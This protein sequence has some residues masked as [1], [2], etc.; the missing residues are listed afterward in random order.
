MSENAFSNEIILV[1]PRE[2]VRRVLA[3]AAAVTPLSLSLLMASTSPNTLMVACGAAFSMAAIILGREK[4]T[5]SDFLKKADPL[6][7]PQHQRYA[8]YLKHLS[9]ASGLKSPP[10]LISPRLS[11]NNKGGLAFASSGHSF[12]WTAL[13]GYK[14]KYI[15]A[16]EMAHIARRDSENAL[17]YVLPLLMGLGSSLALTFSSLSATGISLLSLSP[18]IL[19][20]LL[21]P[22]MPGK[23][24]T[25]LI[26]LEAER[27]AVEIT[28]Q[29]PFSSYSD[30]DD[31]AR[32]CARIGAPHPVQL[33]A[34]IGQ[35]SPLNARFNNLCAKICKPLTM[36][37]PSPVSFH[38]LGK[39]TP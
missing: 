14:T 16:H 4:H 5:V 13:A 22:N 36:K 17:N 26:E 8:L 11:F 10:T 34:A 21:L 39:T 12:V 28:G 38:E 18:V 32:H 23:K 24:R 25:P 37:R 20:S 7:H 30:S 35:T 19:S 1:T 33:D 29:Q 27:V 3:Q 15:L 9:D 31:I 2:R 6:I